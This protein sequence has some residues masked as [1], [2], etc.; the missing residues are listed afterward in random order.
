L[1][2]TDQSLDSIKVTSYYFVTTSCLKNVENSAMLVL[3][4]GQFTRPVSRLSKSEVCASNLT[5]LIW[6]AFI[7]KRQPRLGVQQWTL[8]HCIVGSPQQK[9]QGL[10]FIIAAG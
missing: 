10:D 6:P 5:I 4:I 2:G 8:I 7:R 9:S 1:A 3:L